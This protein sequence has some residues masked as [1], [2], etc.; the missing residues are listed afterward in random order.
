LLLIFPK[1]DINGIYFEVKNIILYLRL[2]TFS[3]FNRKYNNK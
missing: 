2:T 1:I 3:V